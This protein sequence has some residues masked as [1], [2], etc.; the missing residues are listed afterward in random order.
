MVQKVL[1]IGGTVPNVRT[2]PTIS[3]KKATEPVSSSL[4]LEALCQFDLLT[5]WLGEQKTTE[6]LDKE[7][8][9]DT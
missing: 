9:A 8:V 2:V 6:S 7:A 4:T 5:A 3:S 1:A